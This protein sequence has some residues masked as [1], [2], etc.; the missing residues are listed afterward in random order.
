MG[1]VINM[2]T[3]SYLKE[4]SDAVLLMWHDGCEHSEGWV[5]VTGVKDLAELAL[6]MLEATPAYQIG[7]REVGRMT[8]DMEI[9]D[10]YETLAEMADE[11]GSNEGWFKV[12]RDTAEATIEHLID[13]RLNPIHLKDFEPTA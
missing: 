9:S 4:R 7:I 11:V 5:K 12:N 6:S 8:P 2:E 1:Q 3:Y 13:I 10:F